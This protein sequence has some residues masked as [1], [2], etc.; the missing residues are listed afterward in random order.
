[1]QELAEVLSRL[2]ECDVRLVYCYSDQTCDS[3]I[4]EKFHGNL[5]DIKT[6]FAIDFCSKE[7]LIQHESADNITPYQSSMSLSSLE[8]LAIQSGK[9]SRFALDPNIPRDKFV[10]LYKT[11]INR[12]LRKEIAEET[13][14][15]QNCDKIV[16]MVTLGQK[17]GRG[18]IGLIAVDL[19]FRGNGYGEQLVRAAQRWFIE[20]G[21]EHGQVVTQERN[22]PACNLYKK[23][24]Y[25]VEKIDY[26]YHFWL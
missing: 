22:I 16:G 6:T 19:N 2:R 26:I 12:S 11:W 8:Q 15:I 4:F 1:M 24:G 10:E 23:C 17:N 9:Y 25:F 21:F 13:L 7:N 5:A 14:V 20:H 3:S 18:D